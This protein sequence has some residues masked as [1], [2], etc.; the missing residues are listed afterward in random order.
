MVAATE[1]FSFFFVQPPSLV[2]D[3][4]SAG[5]IITI[6]RGVIN[7][8]PAL[9]TSGRCT[10]PVLS[11]KS[12][13]PSFLF[14]FLSYFRCS[15]SLNSIRTYLPPPP[16]A[17]SPSLPRAP[18]LARLPW[19]RVPLGFVLRYYSPRLSPFLAPPN[20]KDPFFLYSHI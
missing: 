5:G 14:P 1:K 11:W 3:S 20:C 2:I 8:V 17:T 12:P 18:F 10:I 6:G 13:C 9:R 15:L 4:L 7:E 19:S 16:P